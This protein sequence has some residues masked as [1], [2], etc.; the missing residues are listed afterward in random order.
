MGVR[1]GQEYIDGLRDDREL[2]VN[3]ELVRDV[4]TYPA[5]QGVIREMAQLYDRQHQEAY[6]DILTYPSPTSNEPVSTSFVLAESWA[7]I[8]KRRFGETAR[9]ELTCGMMGRLPDYMNAFVA[10]MAAI[11]AWLGRNEPRFGDNAGRIMSCG[12]KRTCV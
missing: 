5:F 11:T 6:K 1:R 7:D 4:T 8:E 2:Y 9:C 3:G 10:D 12:A